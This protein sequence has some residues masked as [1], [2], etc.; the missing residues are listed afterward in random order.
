MY[1]NTY[2]EIAKAQSGD[3]E[4]MTSLVDN[5]LGLVY[6]IAKRFIGRGFEL[7]DLKQVGTIGLI[8]SIKNFN[9]EFS[10]Q[11][12][13]Y[14]VP[15]IMGEIKRYIRDDGTIK[16]SRSIKELSNKIRQIQKEYLDKKGKEIKI[17]EISKIL[18]V[19][20]EEIAAAID[21]TSATIVTS[22]NEPINSGDSN[23]QSTIEEIIPDNKDEEL[24]IANKLTINKLIEELPQ[25]EREIVM[26][27]Y[28]Y[29]KTQSEVANKLGISQVQVSRIEKKILISMKRKLVG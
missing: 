3:N 10:V 8:K 29:G 23:K 18:K 19:P 11:L 12:S 27:R 13:T 5:N 15:F 17:E 7:E 14:A 25:R 22:F 4:A 24:N 21:A 26:L 28:F 6:N 9:N 16:V 20:K 2:E 1:N